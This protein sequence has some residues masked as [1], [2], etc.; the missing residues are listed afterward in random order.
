MRW[1]WKPDWEPTKE[2]LRCYGCGWDTGWIKYGTIT[3]K[4]VSSQLSLI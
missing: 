4:P 2:R 3:T 1:Q